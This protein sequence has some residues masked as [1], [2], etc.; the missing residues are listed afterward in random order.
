MSPFWKK[1][2]PVLITGEF[3][4]KFKS[5]KDAKDAKREVE[6]LPTRY[7]IRLSQK[8]VPPVSLE[9]D[10][11]MIEGAYGDVAKLSYWLSSWGYNHTIIKE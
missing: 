7:R 9:G 11:L 2:K 5:N 3:R 4:L 8:K 6:T 1:E 10:T